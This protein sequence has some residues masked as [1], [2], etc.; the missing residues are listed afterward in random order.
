MGKTEAGTIWLDAERTGPYD[1]YQF[2]RNTEDADVERFLS[3]FT[4]LEMEEVRELGAL[5]GEEIN[6]AKQRL[7]FEATSP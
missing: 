6:R 2:W 4:Y 5:K 7:A 3:F 1:Y